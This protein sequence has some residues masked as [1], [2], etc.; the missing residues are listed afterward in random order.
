MKKSVVRIL[1]FLLLLG[2]VLGYVNRVL[3]VKD[4][5]GIYNLKKFYELKDDTVDVLVLGSSHAF[6]NINTGTLWDEHGIASFVLG[7]SV[8]PMWNTYYYLKEALKTQTPKLIV[9]EPYVLCFGKEYGDDPRIIKNTF[10]LKW[11]RDKIEDIMV[12]VPRE[13]WAEFMLEYVQY[14]TRYSQLSE[15]DFLRDKGDV[16]YR[17]WKGFGC[18]M[19]TMVC[20]KKDL[21]QVTESYPM[22]EKTEEYFR[23]F[24]ELAN[25]NNIPVLIITAPYAAVTEYEQQIYN[26]VK[27]LAASY[28]ADFINYNLLYDELGLDFSMDMA[29]T[30]HLNYRGNRKF[31]SALGDYIAAHYSVPDR[32]GDEAYASWERNARYISAQIANQ[33]LKEASGL[34]EILG[35]LLNPDYMLCMSV[36]GTCTTKAPELAALWEALRI[37]DD[38]DS[39]VWLIDNGAGVLYRSGEAESSQYVKWDRH[40]LQMARAWN[41]EEEVYQNSVLVDQADP[42]KV[43]NGVNIIVYSRTTQEVA[44][45]IGFDQDSGFALV[46]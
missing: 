26:G 22:T 9:F 38:A 27:E 25:E 36:D 45:S 35:K 29:D 8:Q 23:K 13:R 21:S 33:E 24:M 7:G 3:S 1:C 5:D 10:G 44:D 43:Q 18:N 17:D 15:E 20:D 2:C 37:T 39:G 19:E 32:R 42:R 40:H 28:G 46:R 14:H 6:E 31:T 16:Y 12:S 30:S 11:S 41:A 4:G 34:A